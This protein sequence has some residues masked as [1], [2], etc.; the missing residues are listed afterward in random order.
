[1]FAHLKPTPP[2]N[3]IQDGDR[4]R[5]D[6]L[7]HRDIQ[8]YLDRASVCVSFGDLSYRVY[9]CKHSRC[10]TKPGYDQQSFRMAHGRY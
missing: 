3:L 9:R 10:M 4:S 1:M 6:T 2:I 7:V 5:R 8:N